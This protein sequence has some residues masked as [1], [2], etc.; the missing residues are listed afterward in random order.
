VADGTAG[1]AAASLIKYLVF[2]KDPKLAIQ[3]CVK[4]RR[5]SEPFQTQE[6]QE[7]QDEEMEGCLEDRKDEERSQQEKNY[8][9]EVRLICSPIR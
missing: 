3:P 2:N 7:E 9:T 4:V 1:T 8:R 6:K 5:L